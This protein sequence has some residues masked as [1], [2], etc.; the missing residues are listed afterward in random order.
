MFDPL[1]ALKPITNLHGDQAFIIIGTMSQRKAVYVAIVGGYECSAADY[2]VAERVGELL[3]QRGVV[4]VT[5][6]RHGITEAACK[7]AKR[8][9]GTTIGILPGEDYREANDYVDHAI[10]TDM[11]SSR[12]HVIIMTADAVIAF[13]GKYGTLSEVA[14]ALLHQRPIVSLG[15]WEVAEEI[16]KAQTPQ[17]AVEKV[18]QEVRP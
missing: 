6:G 12:N 9:G 1:I 16:I 2:A 3:A 8:G 5:G 11:G 4:V 10:C 17:E 14:Y 18:L 13:P 15:S 7:G